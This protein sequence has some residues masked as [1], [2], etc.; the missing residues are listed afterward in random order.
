MIVIFFKSCQIWLKI[1]I[2]SNL[3]VLNSIFGSPR[4]R[5][6]PKNSHQCIHACVR[7]TK[8]SESVHRNFLK[9]GTKLG[10]PNVTEVTFSD[11]ARKILFDPFWANLGP[12]MPFLAQNGHI[13]QF[14]G[15]ESQDLLDF[16]YLNCILGLFMK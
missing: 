5:A 16:A 6:E 7:P 2:L 12:K 14:L 9:S 13:V 8:I 15:N 4:F 11:F 1:C 10:F 3:M